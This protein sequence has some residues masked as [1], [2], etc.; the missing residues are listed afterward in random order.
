MQKFKNIRF[1]D[2]GGKTADR[3]T[4]VFLDRLERVTYIS[5]GKAQK[6]YEA[7]GFDSDPF[8]PLGFGQHCTA[9]VG[10]HL[11]KRIDFSELPE[12]AQKFV[13]QNI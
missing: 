7:L 12:N 13:I 6:L 1:Y 4:A 8:H 9:A 10:R 11:G 2:K 5:F 3:Y